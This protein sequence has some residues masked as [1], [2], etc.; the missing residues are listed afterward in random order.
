MGFQSNFL[1]IEVQ[2]IGDIVSH[3]VIYIIFKYQIE[4]HLLIF[5]LYL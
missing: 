1:L 2:L 5:L 3:F 4:L